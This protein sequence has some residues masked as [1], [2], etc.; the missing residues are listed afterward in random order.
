MKS[1]FALPPWEQEEENKFY[2]VSPDNPT[3]N[4][5]QLKGIWMPAQYLYAEDLSLQEKILMSF[6][7]MLDQEDHCYASN[8]YLGSLIGTSAKT[9]SNM[10]I[11]LKKKNY[12]EQMSWDGNMRIMRC[13]K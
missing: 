9:V 11:A 6:I 13:L 2:K 7:F 8:K 5:K 12:L 1:D 3:I 10:L 4:P